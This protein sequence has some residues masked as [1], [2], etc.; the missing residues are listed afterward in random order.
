MIRV[1][2]FDRQKKTLSL[3]EKLLSINN[4]EQY[5]IS[6]HADFQGDIFEASSFDIILIAHYSSTHYVL[7][8]IKEVVHLE[9]PIP[10][11]L[12]TASNDLDLDHSAMGL[13]AADCIPIPE[14]TESLL[15]RT[16][17]HAIGRKNTEAQLSFVATHDQLTGL[18]NRY[19]F[20]EHLSHSIS[21]AKRNNNSFGLLFLD[22]DQFKRINDSLGHDIGDML[23]IEVANRIRN[24]VRTTDIVA[25]MGGD[26]FTILVNDINNK[27]ELALIAK[28]IQLALDPVVQ[29]QNQEL[30]VTI[31]IGIAT[32]PECGLEPQTLMKSADIAL[33]KAKEI[34]RNK[35]QYFSNELNEQ[36][37]LKL[38][39]EK[40]LRRALIKG[41]FEIYFQPQVSAIDKN[42]TG[43]EALL[44]WNHPEIGI[45]S[46]ADFIPLLEELSL[47]VGVEQW[48]IR[49]VCHTAKRLTDRYGELKFAINISGSHFKLGNL[50]Q[51]IYLALQ[52]S[53]LE[54]AFLEIELTE[55]IMIE[56]VEK[57]NHTLNELADIG[58]SISLDDFGKGY[59]SLSYL[60]NF[61][62]NVLKIDKSFIDNIISCKRDHSIVEAIIGLSHQLDIQVVAE[63]VEDEM[64]ADTLRTMHC[65]YIQGYFF[66]R[67]MP[68]LELESYL[69]KQFI[70]PKKKNKHSTTTNL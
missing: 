40:S 36:A 6:W 2:L 66:A 59:S 43:F 51:S 37:R 14:L 57:N 27:K 28:K 33:N 45:V 48:V 29:I 44:R 13:G 18:A 25:R 12:L 62:A 10:L 39:L 64:Q 65:D 54:A 8:I 20:H 47:I 26:E 35:F 11:V 41:E 70:N 56:Y 34:G 23:I 16:I 3:V 17:R 30:Y 4:P 5:E 1:L 67:P 32:F 53:S 55:D 38:E 22:L 50:K 60:K 42:V 24:T 15:Q 49:K 46:P 61:P 68:E 52:E 58:V 9:L 7:D 19:L 21:V 31:S 63:G 69:S